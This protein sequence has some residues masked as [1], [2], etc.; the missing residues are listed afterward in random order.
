MAALG[1]YVDD[2]TIIQLKEKFNE[3]RLYW[4][5]ADKDYT[6]EE[7]QEMKNLYSIINNILRTYAE[8]SYHTCVICG[9]PATEWT[10]DGWIESY[11]ANCYKERFGNE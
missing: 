5:W 1:K 7:S 2:F 9:K 11:C 10:R 8:I 3:I 4:C 6:D